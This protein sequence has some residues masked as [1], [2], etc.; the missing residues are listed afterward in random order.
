MSIQSSLVI[1]DD[2]NLSVQL[3]FQQAIYNFFMQASGIFCVLRGSE[4]I[5]ELANP[6]YLHFIGRREIIGKSFEEVL[7]ELKAQ[8]FSDILDKVYSSKI[9]YS[10]NEMYFCFK[11][12]NGKQREAYANFTFQPVLNPKGESIGIIISG[13]D[14]TEQIHTRKKM[15]ELE[16]RMRLAVDASNI[17][18][19]DFNILTGEVLSSD[20]M[21]EMF[22]I[23]GSLTL[24]QYFAILKLNDEEKRRQIY[25]DSLKSGSLNYQFIINRPDGEKKWIETSAKV[26]YNQNGV[27]IRML[28]TVK[29]ITEHKAAEE[30][31]AILAAIVESSDD[32][33]LSKGLDGIVTSW[34]DAGKHILGYEAIEMIGQPVSKLIP[35]DRLQEEEEIISRLKKGERIEHFETQRVKKDGSTID[36]SLTISPVK[37]S[38]G[39]V[40]GASKIARDITKQKQSE[41]IISENE[42]RLKIL[43]EASE[44][45]TWDL[46]LLTREVEYSP[47]YLEIFGYNKDAVLTHEELVNHLHPDDLPIRKLAFEEAYRTGVLHY[48]SRLVWNDKSIHWMEGKGKVLYDEHGTP[49]KMMGTIRDITSEMNYQKELEKREEVF[50]LLADSLPQH[51]WT[52]DSEGNMDYFNQSVYNYSGM[53]AEELGKEGWLHLVHPYE[54]E[55]NR[56]AW[57]DAINAGELFKA[58]HQFRRYDGQYRWQLSRAVPQKDDEGNIIRWLGTST[59]VHDWK[60][61]TNEL[62]EQV[63]Q[64]TRQLEESN[65]GLSKLNNELAQFAYVASHDLQEPLRKIQTFS[66]RIQ[67]IEK[68]N[69]SEKGKDYFGRLQNASK[70]MQQL[71]LDLL[72]YSRANTAERHFEKIDLNDLLEGIEEQL[73]ESIQQKNAVIEAVKLPV[74]SIVRYQFEQLFTNLL[75]NALKFS[76]TDV[77]PLIKIGCEI[78]SGS[79]IDEL[80][81]D[82]ALDYYHISFKDNGIGFEPEYNEAVFQVFKRLHGKDEYPGTGIG[83]AIVKKIVENHYGVITASGVVGN[84]ATF[85]MYFPVGE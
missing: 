75:T 77:N 20:I 36:I 72:A 23:E 32:L 48:I 3:D 49:Y 78:L 62:E 10:G 54:K 26:Y 29:D 55:S 12:L 2:S 18:I 45:G 79:A 56:K 59:D 44:L 46:N 31:M 40:I 81:I 42:E 27:A 9:T 65:E 21:N 53:Q 70:R 64:R 83:L 43:I 57:F 41:R 38:Q 74:L 34:N 17:G 84:G 19:Y 69:L 60:L 52:S 73:R 14:M 67:E 1:P 24:E 6:S 11:D 71:I 30:K 7:P 85:D 82:K 35:E 39:E 15:E 37:N 4:Y 25:Q 76:K 58:E 22:G 61:F 63:R 33:I 68:N 51:I 13:Y 66:A 50:R 47:R 16:E 28:G 5:Y 80:G 8:G